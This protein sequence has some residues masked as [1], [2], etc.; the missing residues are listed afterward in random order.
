MFVNTNSR[1]PYCGYHHFFEISINP[2]SDKTAGDLF[3][4]INSD[5]TKVLS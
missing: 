2:Q 3:L 4:K 5:S 1:S